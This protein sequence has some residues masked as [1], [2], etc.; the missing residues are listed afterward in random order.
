MMNLMFN[1]KR[2]NFEAYATVP[3]AFAPH[4]V[5]LIRG[6]IEKQEKV[7]G[8]ISNGVDDKTIRDSRIKWLLDDTSSQW[9][10]ERV[11]LLATNVNEQ[12]FGMELRACEGIQLTE[13]DSEY[14]GFYGS[15][16]D[17]MYG[18]GG[19]SRFRKLSITMQLSDASEYEGGDLL[20]YPANI[21]SPITASRDKGTMTLFR[22]HIIHEVVPVTKGIRYSFVTWVHGPLFK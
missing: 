2:E 19:P 9:I 11:A 6:M 4:E 15:H 18:P 12:Y 17:S 7:A 10:F 22:S 14:Q 21:K 16:T 13:Y 3:N 5:D 8:V 1:L 20:L